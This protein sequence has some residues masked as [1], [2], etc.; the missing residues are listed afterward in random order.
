MKRSSNKIIF[1][2]ILIFFSCKE[3]ELGVPEYLN[4][5]RNP[6]NGLT[7]SII[8]DSLEFKASIFSREYM[9]LMNIGE[10]VYF[11]GKTELDSAIST[12]EDFTYIMLEWDNDKDQKVN[13]PSEYNNVTALLNNDLPKQIILQTGGQSIPC[14]ISNPEIDLY[15]AKNKLWLGFP[16]NLKTLR[17][18]LSLIVNAN[19]ICRSELQVDFKAFSHNNIPSLIVKNL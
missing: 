1:G 3:R 15:G 16:K 2:L 5:F 13:N 17:K 12:M 9:T 14:V 18:P 19:T 8:K 6:N 4:H 7:Q 10:N 11:M